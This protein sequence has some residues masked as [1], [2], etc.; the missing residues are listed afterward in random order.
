MT[1]LNTTDNKTAATS[2]NVASNGA[3]EPKSAANASLDAL[4]AEFEPAKTVAHTETTQTQQTATTEPKQTAPTISSDEVTAVK[5]L[6]ATENQKRADEGIAKAVSF[7]QEN[8]EALLSLP[9]RFV[10]GELYKRAATD[11]RFLQAFMLRD[12]QPDTWNKVLKAIA[13]DL[14]GDITKTQTNRLASDR[15]RV[16]ASVRGIATAPISQEAVS[17]EDLGK[18]SHGRFQRFKGLVAAGKSQREAYNAV[19]AQPQR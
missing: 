10:E 15:A 3:A 14:E 18:L 12:S 9:S 17:N 13:S 11:K 19:T 5:S 2:G 1:A 8:A 16:H 6:L 7:I 4:L